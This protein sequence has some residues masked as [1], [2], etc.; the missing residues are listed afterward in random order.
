MAVLFVLKFYFSL[1]FWYVTVR[2]LQ[3]INFKPNNQLHFGHDDKN[4]RNINKKWKLKYMLKLVCIYVGGWLIST[5]KISVFIL[6][7]LFYHI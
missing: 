3:F 4:N 1:I 2:P 6:E 5:P 7:P